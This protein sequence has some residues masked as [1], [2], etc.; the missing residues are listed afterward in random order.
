ML[1]LRNYKWIFIL[2]TGIIAIASTNV[3]CTGNA[4]NNKT[5]LT[6]AV[7]EE[8]PLSGGGVIVL[9]DQNFTETI[10]KGVTVVDFWAT[11]CRPCRMQAPIMEELSNQMAG[12]A[13]I[14]KLDVDQ[15][16]TLS[17]KYNVQS[18]PT[19][20]IFKDGKVVSQ[21]VGVTSKEI[22]AQEINKFLK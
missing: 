19:I 7:S 3:C 2:A 15:N 22:I 1:K 13:N 9:N 4:A 5:D 17:Q 14:C 8:K 20:L 16:Q 6:N 18:I 11:W 10:K 12:K 21:F